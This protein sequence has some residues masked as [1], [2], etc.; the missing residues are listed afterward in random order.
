VEASTQ[1][2]FQVDWDTSAGCGGILSGNYG[3]VTYKLGGRYKNS[4][5]CTWTLYGENVKEFKFTLGRNGFESCC[6]YIILNSLNPENGSL[7]P[8]VVLKTAS[9]FAT[10]R[11]PT[12]FI[13][14]KSDTSVAGEGFS[15]QF[16]GS[17]TTNT[18]TTP[19]PYAANTLSGPRIFQIPP[20][21]DNET[22]IHAPHWRNTSTPVTPATTLDSD[23][24]H[25]TQELEVDDHGIEN[26]MT[27]VPTYNYM[28]Y[29]SRRRNAS[30]T[31][32]RAQGFP[33]LGPNEI[34]TF[35]YSPEAG[36]HE[37]FDFLGSQVTITQMHLKLEENCLSDSVRIYE[38]NISD[39]IP[40]REFT[41]D[42]AS[43]NMT[44]CDQDAPAAWKCDNCPALLTRSQQLTFRTTQIGFIV[45]FKSVAQKQP[46]QSFSIDWTD[47]RATSTS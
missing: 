15:L 11:G 30:F 26:N 18:T 24:E 33:S 45:I 31:Y 6:D 41:V 14:F 13:T 34:L 17:F 47:S 44:V 19:S 4:E 42:Q 8:S 35:V 7:D 28:H 39:M 29:H 37:S 40:A 23:Y 1:Q 5:Q 43:P 20:L 16:F 25:V 3:R 36:R 21:A 32:P 10:V 9:P 46:E 2:H 38:R 22:L 27:V 12:V